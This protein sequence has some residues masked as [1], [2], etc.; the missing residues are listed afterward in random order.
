MFSV[1]TFTDFGLSFSSTKLLD[2]IHLGYSPLFS[3]Y[4]LFRDT[5]LH[6]Y[7]DITGQ[8]LLLCFPLP[9]PPLF[10]YTICFLVCVF[11]SETYF[12]TQ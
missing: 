12:P 2:T 6:Y 8:I 1:P 10:V 5:E 11:L 3:L 4:T 9:P 7:E